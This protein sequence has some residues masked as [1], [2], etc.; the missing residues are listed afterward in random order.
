MWIERLDPLEIGTAYR[1]GFRAGDVIGI[2]GV[3][4]PNIVTGV[5]MVKRVLG[6][7]T[8]SIVEP[9]GMEIP[10]KLRCTDCH[11]P[12]SYWTSHSWV[13]DHDVPVRLTH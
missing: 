9:S 12:G 11:I 13:G 10:T 1:H 3:A 4:G 6:P 2:Y 7:Y 8:F 5:R